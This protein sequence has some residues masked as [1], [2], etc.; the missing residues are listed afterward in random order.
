MLVLQDARFI[1]VNQAALRM[2]GYELTDADGVIG[3][4]P[5]RA[6]A[7]DAAR[8]RPPPQAKSEQLA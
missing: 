8:W 5:A 2:L 6:F 1:E 7:G 3:K 4:Q